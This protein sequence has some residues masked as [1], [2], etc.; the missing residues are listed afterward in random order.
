ME[1]IC[2]LSQEVIDVI[3][4]T[5]SLYPHEESGGLLIGMIKSNEYY[6]LKATNGG[7]ESKHSIASFTP[8]LNFITKKIEEYEDKG[9]IFLG[10][11]HRHPDSM[12]WPSGGDIHAVQSYFSHNQQLN[13]YIMII[14]N[15]L[16]SKIDY[17]CFLFQN[18]GNYKEIEFHLEKTNE[19]PKEKFNSEI[20]KENWQ[21]SDDLMRKRYP[22]F[23]YTEDTDNPFYEGVIRKHQ[24]RV[25][26]PSSPLN[27]FLFYI[28][29]PIEKNILENLAQNLY[30][31]EISTTPIALIY[32]ETILMEKEYDTTYEKEFSVNNNVKKNFSSI[33]KTI[34]KLKKIFSI[35]SNES[36]DYQYWYS[37]PSGNRRLQIEVEELKNKY[38]DIH[39]YKKTNGQICFLY[40]SHNLSLLF[41]C[42]DDYPYSPPN[43]KIME[44]IRSIGED[45]KSLN[46]WLNN[47]WNT[48]MYLSEIIKMLI[49]R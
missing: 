23:Q 25:Y 42:P 19:L 16:Q 4:N 48:D 8:D 47:N 1:S 18:N 37:S 20:I 13:D 10:E 9:Y 49:R 38:N 12:A 22:E 7:P 27:K 46:E 40:R 21:I 17:H 34:N 15:L 33:E 44:G 28:D 24:V 26:P 36:P 35:I 14:V 3:R 6:I 41:L 11:W 5:T 29:P 30:K 45:N 31:M 43:V 39:I 32:L 2:Y